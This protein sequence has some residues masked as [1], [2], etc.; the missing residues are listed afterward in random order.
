[1]KGAPRPTLLLPSLISHQRFQASC[2]SAHIFLSPFATNE[3]SPHGKPRN[4]RWLEHSHDEPPRRAWHQSIQNIVRRLWNGCLHMLPSRRPWDDEHGIS[5]S[6]ARDNSTCQRK[7]DDF[8]AHTWWLAEFPLL[9]R[10]AH[11]FGRG[12]PFCCNSW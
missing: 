1:M 9:L 2:G 3:T 4:A 7:D 11:M 12:G 8:D 5:A 10:I 6:T